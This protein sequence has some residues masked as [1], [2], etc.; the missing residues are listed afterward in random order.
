[1]ILQTETMTKKVRIKSIKKITSTSDRYDIETEKYHCF[2]ADDILVHNSQFILGHN[3]DENETIV[4][5]K[6]MLKRGLTLQDEDDNTYWMAS[7]N[8]SIVEKIK[9]S[10]DKGVVQVFGEV[11]PVQKGYNYG[12]S[13]PTVRIFDIRVDGNSIPY[14]KVSDEFKEIWVPIIYDGELKLIEKEVVLFSDTERGIHKTKKTYLLSDEITN[15]CKGMEQVSGKQH[16]IREGVVL[17]PYIDRD[18][19]DGTKLRLKIINPKYKET[20]EEIN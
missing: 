12:Q 18:A 11:I 3:L 2:F 15:L 1:M 20:G 6:G 16:H 14:D 7:K 13:K 10:F 9:N 8:D 4:S 5:S 17:R 19:K